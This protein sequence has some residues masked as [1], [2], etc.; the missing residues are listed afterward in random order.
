[1]AKNQTTKTVTGTNNEQAQPNL[2]GNP[3]PAAEFNSDQAKDQ[4]ENLP[5][6]NLSIEPVADPV[7]APPFSEETKES[8]EETLEDLE[9]KIKYFQGKSKLLKQRE[10]V[11]AMQGK[12]NDFTFKQKEEE[13]FETSDR[14]YRGCAITIRD[15]KGDTFEIYNPYLITKVIETLNIECE[16]KIVKINEDIRA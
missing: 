12:L 16:I 10:A 1:M 14:Y 13:N 15:D 3:A 2:Q 11:Q 6:G 4:K 9:K 7:A 8:P 5:V